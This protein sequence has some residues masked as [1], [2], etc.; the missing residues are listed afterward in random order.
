MPPSVSVSDLDPAYEGHDHVQPLS[1]PSSVESSLTLTPTTHTLSKST[2]FLSHHTPSIKFAPLPHTGPK[3]R[4]LVPLGVA[5][6]S[7]RR[8]DREGSPIQLVEPTEEPV[9]DPLITL[10]KFVV[11]TSRSLW[12]RVRKKSGVVR[13]NHTGSSSQ[14]EIV[15]IEVVDKEIGNTERREGRAEQ[16]NA[17]GSRG[18]PSRRSSWSPSV[19]RGLFD[20]IDKRAARR[21]TGTLP[22]IPSFQEIRL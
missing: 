22:P 7:R 3:K 20:G 2:S 1:E 12:K 4:R 11:S 15:V 21:S 13:E 16:I 10:G 14:D 8:R 9:E 17:F 19:E 5:G 6:R 18:L